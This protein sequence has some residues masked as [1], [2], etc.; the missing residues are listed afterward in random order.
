MAAG[1]RI[2]RRMF[3]AVRKHRQHIDR[4]RLQPA[5]Q[6]V[7]KGQ[8]AAHPVRPV[9][10]HADIGAAGDEPGG[11]VV[12]NAAALSN[13]GM[14]DALPGHRRRRLV[15]VVAAQVSIGQK[16]EQVAEIEDAAAH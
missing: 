9:K 11:D 8:V 16:E 4:L 5:N 13:L 14:V 3:Q 10:Q 1:V 15:A 12:V 2:V 7:N 6:V